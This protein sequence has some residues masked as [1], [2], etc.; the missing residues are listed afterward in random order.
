MLCQT[1]WMVTS[2]KKSVNEHTVPSSELSTGHLFQWKQRKHIKNKH[3]LHLQWHL[4]TLTLICS[5]L[6][7]K[8]P[9]GTTKCFGQTPL[10]RTSFSSCIQ[11]YQSHSTWPSSNTDCHHHYFPFN[12]PKLSKLVFSPFCQTLMARIIMQTRLWKNLQ[13]SINQTCQETRMLKL[14][15]FYMQPFFSHPW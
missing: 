2:H 10:Y 3:K 11:L 14:N 12:P 8:R 15:C 9:C 7:Q 4:C 5:S 13:V 1:T 6:M